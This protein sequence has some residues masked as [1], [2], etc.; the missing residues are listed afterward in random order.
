[1]ADGL[2]TVRELMQPEPI[3]VL[4][5]R[6]VGEVLA[7]MNQFR[8]GAVVVVSPSHSLLGIFTERDLLR[9]I[10]EANPGWRDLPVSTWMTSKPH[11]VGPDRAGKR[12][13]RSWIACAFGTFRSW[14]TIAS[15]ALFPPAC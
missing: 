6:P 7:L 2:L 5:D 13:P 10:V 12:L 15:S 4:P 3:V 1:M 14:R 11:A 8:I 9:R